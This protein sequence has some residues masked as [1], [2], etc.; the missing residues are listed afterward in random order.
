M[1]LTNW[2]FEL[3]CNKGTQVALGVLKGIVEAGEATTWVILDWSDVL[4]IS[5]VLALT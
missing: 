1:R 4:Q 5:W 2:A 3:N